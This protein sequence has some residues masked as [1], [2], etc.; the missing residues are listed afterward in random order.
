M[1]PEE[2]GPKMPDSDG[3]DRMEVLELGRAENLAQFSH[4]VRPED[5]ALKP[6]LCCP[7]LFSEV[8]FDD[9]G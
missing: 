6:L 5:L 2:L 4:A 9:T 1:I 3:I 8:S 7:S